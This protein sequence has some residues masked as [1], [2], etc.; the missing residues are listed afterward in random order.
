MIK[1]AEKNG[2][3][4]F[5]TVG[6]FWYRNIYQKYRSTV[7]NKREKTH[8]GCKISNLSGMLGSHP[9]GPALGSRSSSLPLGAGEKA[10]ANTG[11]A[12]Y[13]IN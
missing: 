4:Y 1:V 5:E 3:K 2:D 9:I 13:T 11:E 8:G 10:A 12:T 7:D 6:A